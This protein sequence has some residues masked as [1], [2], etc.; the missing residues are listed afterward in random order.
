MLSQLSYHQ[1]SPPLESQLGSSNHRIA[2]QI[3]TRAASVEP[4]PNATATTKSQGHQSIWIPAPPLSRSRYNRQVLVPAI[5]ISG[6]QKICDAKVL[7]IGLGGLGSAASLYLAG[8]GVH[9]LGLGD[10]DAVETSNLQR[11]VVHREATVGMSKVDSAAETLMT[12]NSAARYDRYPTALTPENALEIVEQYDIVLDCTD[13]PATRYLISD[14]CVLLGKPLVSAAAQRTEGQLMVLNHPPG[15]VDG[16][17]ATAGPCYRCVF[18]TP[19][20]PE[21]VQTCSE[22]G[23]LGPVVGTVGV[24]MATE[25]IKLIVASEEEKR[26][27]KPSLLLY[28]AFN[29]DPR[30]VFRSVGLRRPRKDCLACGDEEELREKGLERISKESLRDG[31]VDYVAFCGAAE[32]VKVLTDEE[33]VEACDF[34]EVMG[35]LEQEGNTD[36]VRVKPVVIDVREVVEYDMGPKLPGSFN[37]PISEILRRRDRAMGLDAVLETGSSQG[38]RPSPVYFVCQ[39]GNDSQI[40]ARKVIEAGI[41]RDEGRWIGDIKGGFHA[42]EG[43]MASTINE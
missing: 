2:D 5:G 24:L 4:S 11:Q 41:G 30:S 10:D 28:N 7:I 22:I 26:T 19:P 43:E 1:P 31:K 3:Q 37:V 40:A 13:N 34:I 21:T 9:V 6:Q 35:K 36:T 29:K 25:T 18:P 8:A 16:P 42:L 20:P 33:R 23:I 17:I 14:T 32:D 12:L 15:G 39:R 27:F 38:T